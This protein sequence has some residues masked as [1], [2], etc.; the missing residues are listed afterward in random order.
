MIPGRSLAPIR[1][2]NIRRL[3]LE[4]TV[5]K[6]WTELELPAIGPIRQFTFPEKDRMLLRTGQGLF[7][8][9]LRPEV[10]MSR[11][12]DAETIDALDNGD[13][14]G[15]ARSQK[16]DYGGESWFFHGADGGDITLCDLSS[17][18]RLEIDFDE[19]GG[20]IIVDGSTAERIQ[21]FPLILA[22]DPDEFSIGGF[23]SDE[24]YLVLCTSREL[25][26]YLSPHFV[27]G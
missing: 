4:F 7:C 27:S 2:M 6:T 3:G 12:M 13:S 5:M 18:E 21:R 10:E 14:W 8:L 16:L 26:I 23:S 9:E 25:R 19:P 20:M 11:V 24:K 1:A 15:E 17:G 22:E